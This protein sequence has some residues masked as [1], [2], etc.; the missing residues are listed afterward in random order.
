MIAGIKNILVKVPLTDI[1]VR[2]RLS[3]DWRR[4]EHPHHHIGFVFETWL[5]GLDGDGG[6]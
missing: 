6:I 2:M 3:R 5:L 1:V 4:N